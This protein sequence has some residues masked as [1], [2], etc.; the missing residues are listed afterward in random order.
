MNFSDRHNAYLE[1]VSR[2]LSKSCGRSVSKKEVV[3]ALLDLAIQDEG[4]FDPDF[5]EQPITAE[6]RAIVQQARDLRTM[7]LEPHE[8]LQIV[9]ASS[10]RARSTDRERH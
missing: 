10:E 9:L 8:L 1:R 3:E 6:R 7:S 5:P 4:I 2:K